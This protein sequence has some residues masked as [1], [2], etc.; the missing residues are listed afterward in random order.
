MASG[1]LLLTKA[2]KEERF[3]NKSW[4]SKNGV[5]NG[6]GGGNITGH[7]GSNRYRKTNRST[8]PSQMSL[9]TWHRSIAPS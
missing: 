6:G 2:S 1:D 3:N 5:G 9:E 8:N 7:R 4:L